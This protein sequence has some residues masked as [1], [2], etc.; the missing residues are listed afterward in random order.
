MDSAPVVIIGAGASGLAAAILLAR[1]GLH[2]TVLDKQEDLSQADEE[3]YPIGVNP[4]GLRVL[5]MVNPEIRKAIEVAGVIDGWSITKPDKEI[6]RLPSGTVIGSTRGRVVAALYDEALSCATAGHALVIKLG[7]KL[8][9][10][11]EDATTLTFTKDGESDLVYQT[12]SSR[13]IDASGCWSRLRTALAAADSSF[14]VET[15]PWRVYYRN[16]FTAAEPP[17]TTLDPKLHYIFTTAGIYAAVL[18]ERRWVFSLSMS[19]DKEEHAYLLQDKAT[20]DAVAKLKAHV[21][22]NVPAAVP[23]LEEAEYTRYFERRAFTGQ[24]VRLSRL[25]HGEAIAFMGDAAHAV[26]PATGEGINAALEDVGVLLTALDACGDGCGGER[27]VTSVTP[28]FDRFDAM[29]REDARAISEYAAWLLLGQQADQAEKNRRTANL[30][31]TAILQ[32]LGAIGAT[33]NDKSFGRFAT[34]CE[35]YSTILAEWKR[36]QYYVRPIAA[37]VVAIP[38]W[39]AARRAIKEPKQQEQEAVAV[40]GEQ[41]PTTPQQDAAL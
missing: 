9:Q 21:A 3:S 35:P 31:V 12:A 19:T 23:M 14:E 4:R 37:A 2:V 11:S 38:N 22:T 25:N 30:I 24:V 10:V 17:A 15:Y 13:V 28:W 33:W 27:A 1:R 18:K 41:V 20:P 8:A 40:V 36:Q 7:W 5:E 6:A 26:L 29:R 34:R 39:L 16:L 32:K